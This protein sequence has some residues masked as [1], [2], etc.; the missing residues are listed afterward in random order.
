LKVRKEQMTKLKSCDLMPHVNALPS[1]SQYIFWAS[2][3]SRVDK[4]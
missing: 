4:M 1:I 2:D 3:R